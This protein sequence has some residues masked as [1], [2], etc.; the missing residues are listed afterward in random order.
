[1]INKLGF[2][3]GIDPFFLLG[4]TVQ[5]SLDGGAAVQIAEISALAL[6]PAPKDVMQRR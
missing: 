2:K 1:L 3:E 4:V 6:V 5:P